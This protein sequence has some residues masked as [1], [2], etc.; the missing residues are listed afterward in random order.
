LAGAV[1]IKKVYMDNRSV[2]GKPDV[3]LDIHLDN[4]QIII[5]TLDI[6]GNDPRFADF[7]DSDFI[8]QPL[9]D[10]TKIYW[11]NGATIAMNEIINALRINK[12]RRKLVRKWQSSAVP[13][14]VTAAALIFTILVYPLIAGTDGMREQLTDDAVP[15]AVT[16]VTHSV[17]FPDIG[18]IAV[19]SGA[20]EVELPFINPGENDCNLYFEIIMD[21][22]PVF[23]S[24]QVKPGDYIVLLLLTEPF[25]VGEYVARLNI[26][27]YKPDST[28]VIARMNAEI[29]IAVK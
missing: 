16:T 5:F 22:K 6:D 10:G 15:L 23:V 24:R 4:G 11:N 9:S 1:K 25:D 21:D 27:A 17:S 20:A 26:S 8:E 18:R 13:I 2:D 28:S 19:P 29:F 14:I 7:A 3:S 12:T